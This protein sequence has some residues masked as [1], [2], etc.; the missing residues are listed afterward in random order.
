MGAQFG[1]RA[2]PFLIVTAT[3]PLIQIMRSKPWKF[4]L[5]RRSGQTSQVVVGERAE[6]LIGKRIKSGLGNL[7]G[8]SLRLRVWGVREKGSGI[9]SPEG[10]GSG[11][12]G[13]FL[14]DTV[15]GVGDN[16]TTPCQSNND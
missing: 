2:G 4:D 8:W 10:T 7:G 14:A 5:L 11:G 13:E 9:Q 3:I 12:G 1:G 16:L 15:S 6:K